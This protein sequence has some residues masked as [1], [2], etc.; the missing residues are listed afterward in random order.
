M[1]PIK[2]KVRTEIEVEIQFPYYFKYE[3]KGCTTLGKIDKNLVY[4]ID[5]DETGPYDYGMNIDQFD[6]IRPGIMFDENHKSSKEEWQAF[7]L[8][9]TKE[10][11]V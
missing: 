1:N 2:V 7:W 6:P 5:V 10:F 8:G 9:I 3:M 4:S 11:D